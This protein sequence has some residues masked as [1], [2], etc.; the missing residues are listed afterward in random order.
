MVK[1][2][3][4]FSKSGEIL[5]VLVKN[6]ITHGTR[7]NLVKSGEIHY[8]GLKAGVFNK[9]WDKLTLSMSDLGAHFMNEL[10]RCSRENKNQGFV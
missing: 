2:G 7:Q 3:T 1:L 10:N 5:K 9:N 6:K 4:R 8:K